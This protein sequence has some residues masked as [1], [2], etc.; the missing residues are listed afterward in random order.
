MKL[1]LKRIQNQAH[2]FALHTEDGR[3][4]PQQYSTSLVS[5]PDDVTRLIVEFIVDKGGNII[6]ED[7]DGA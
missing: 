1:I 5:K 6:V 4:L 3:R 2:Q 7:G